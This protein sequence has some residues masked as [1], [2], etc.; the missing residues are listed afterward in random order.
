MEN[1]KRGV[2]AVN[3]AARLP[4][5]PRNKDAFV[6]PAAPCNFWTISSGLFPLSAAAQV[7]RPPDLQT[8]R[9]PLTPSSWCRGGIT[10]PPKAALTAGGQP[11]RNPAELKN[12]FHPPSKSQ[13]GCMKPPQ[14]G[15]G[16]AKPCKVTGTS[17]KPWSELGPTLGLPVPGQL[18]GIFTALGFSASSSIING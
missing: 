11:A 7:G 12:A 17:S 2:F 15:P 8:S 18:G 4:P 10:S 9:P 13:Y 3:T 16:G 6:A 5:S 14:P 1:I